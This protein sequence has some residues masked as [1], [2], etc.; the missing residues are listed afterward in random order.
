MWN[1]S[2]N[3]SWIYKFKVSVVYLINER[4]IVK[5]LL[6]EPFESHLVFSTSQWTIRNENIK[7]DK[8][9]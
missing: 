6:L 8:V 7:H 1:N 2:T 5:Y 3:L 9:I 4:G